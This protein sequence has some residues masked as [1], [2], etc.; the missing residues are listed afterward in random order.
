MKSKLTAVLLVAGGVAVG[1]ALGTAGSAAADDYPEMAVRAQL[2]EIRAVVADLADEIDVL[3]AR[4]D[5]LAGGRPK[6]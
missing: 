5:R 2:D 4:V 3:H 6:M 1:L